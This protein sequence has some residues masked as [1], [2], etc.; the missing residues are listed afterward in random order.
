MSL[1]FNAPRLTNLQDIEQKGVDL[2]KR[3]C[4]EEFG[5]N[6]GVH[7]QI[8]PISQQKFKLLLSHSISNRI[9]PKLPE[10]FSTEATKCVLLSFFF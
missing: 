8:V 4:H 7:S 10:A 6:I 9:T 2:S 1:Q 3:L 5:G